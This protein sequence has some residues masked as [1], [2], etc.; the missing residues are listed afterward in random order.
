[1]A[2]IIKNISGSTVEVVA[3]AI[4]R[5]LAISR[6]SAIVDTPAYKVAI[7]DIRLRERKDYCGNHPNACPIRP[8][9][10]KPHKKMSLLEGADWIGFNDMLN[11]VLDSLAVSA[12]AASSLCIIRKGPNRRMRYK[13]YL[14]ANGIDREWERDDSQYAS[15][16]HKGHPP[17]DYPKDTPGIAEWRLEHA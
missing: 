15:Y 9:G 6:F 1:M 16:I 5:A 13:G 12:S 10:H 2:F 14:L 11:D 7:R 3:S 17:T 8:G 4:R